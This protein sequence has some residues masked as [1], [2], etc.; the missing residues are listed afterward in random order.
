[1][2]LGLFVSWSCLETVADSHLVPQRKTLK[3]FCRTWT[4]RPYRSCDLDG[5]I[6]LFPSPWRL[7]MKFGLKWPK[8][9]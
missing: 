6:F 8:G 9:F 5:F 4:F 3:C 2:R 1:M 7:H